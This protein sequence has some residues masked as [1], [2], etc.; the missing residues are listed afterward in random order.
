[1]KGGGHMAD[2]SISFC[3]KKFINPY[4]IAASPSSD[5]LEK[6]ERAFHAGWGGAV[7]KTI[8][9][10]GRQRTLAEPNMG[11]LDFMGRKQMAFY[12]YDL[13]T[14][15]TMEELC[16]EI[17]CLKKHFPDRIVMASIMASR[18]EEWSRMVRE[19][20]DAGADM[21]ECSVSCP[22]GDESGKIPAAD[23]QT[24]TGCVEMIR[25]HLRKDV[26]LVVKLTPN[27][28]D[29]VS[30]AKAAEAGGADAL[31]AIDTVKSFIGIDIETGLPK[32]NVNGQAAL[33]GLSGPA[34]K[35]IA[36]GCAA[37]ICKNVKIPVCGVGGISTYEDALEFMML[38]CGIVELC[39]AVSRYG[40]GMIDKLCAGLR[41]YMDRKGIRSLEEIRGSSLHTIVSQD[42]LERGWNAVNITDTMKCRKCGACITACQDCGFGALTKGEGGIPLLAAEKCRG[43]G[44]CRTV[45]PADCIEI[46]PAV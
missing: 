42:E 28:T 12:N 11:A 2:I 46:R 32:L 24:L 7:L 31:C 17:T 18:E 30:I 23:P 44:V 37:Q 13:C 38:G 6:V 36:L 35:P 21:I 27:V 10:A 16:R 29:I 4:V 20:A 33:G 39:T 22:Q 25:K 5:S 19:A 26:P 15:Q 45:C 41:G 1:M 43:C 14:Q 3:G 8:E 40:Y 9:P 34:V